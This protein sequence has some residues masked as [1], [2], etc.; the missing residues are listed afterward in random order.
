MATNG[1]MREASEIAAEIQKVLEL[2]DI[3]AGLAALNYCM[4]SL[5]HR[6]FDGDEE[7]LAN[8]DEQTRWIAKV[9][10]AERQH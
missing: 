2:H 7:A 5:I 6:H 8:S 3:D 10:R 1:Q 4:A 9:L